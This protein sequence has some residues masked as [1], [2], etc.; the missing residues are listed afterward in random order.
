MSL[1]EYLDLERTNDSGYFRLEVS[2][3]YGYNNPAVDH[4][5]SLDNDI[6]ASTFV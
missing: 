3:Y 4:V 2:A 6:N 1:E 5:P